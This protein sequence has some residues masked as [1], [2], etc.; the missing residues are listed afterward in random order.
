MV[1]FVLHKPIFQDPNKT[2][3]EQLLIDVKFK[4]ETKCIQIMGRRIGG[5]KY[6]KIY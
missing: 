1:A 6:T 5:G 4:T 3:N 2:I